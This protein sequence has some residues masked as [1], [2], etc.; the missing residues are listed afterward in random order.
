MAPPSSYTG[1]AL[2]LNLRLLSFIGSKAALRGF[3]LALVL[4]IL[5]AL[6]IFVRVHPSAY[7]VPLHYSSKFGVDMTGPWYALYYLP[8]VGLLLITMNFA[9]A[10]YGKTKGRVVVYFLTAATILEA[11]LVLVTTFLFLGRV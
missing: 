4:D 9:L 3:V 11:V 7:Q 5:A 10:S 1:I 8:L 6:A 2:K